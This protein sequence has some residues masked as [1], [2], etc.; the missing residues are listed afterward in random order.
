MGTDCVTCVL[1][2][3]GAVLVSLRKEMDGYPSNHGTFLQKELSGKAISPYSP[4]TIDFSIL[5][6]DLNIVSGMGDL[7]TRLIAT[8]KIKHP[9]RK[10]LV[11]I[12][13]CCLPGGVMPDG[14]DEPSYWYV[15]QLEDSLLHV[16][17]HSSYPKSSPHANED[18]SIFSG[19]LESKS[20][21]E[22][23]RGEGPQIP[24]R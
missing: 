1:D 16:T 21:T 9:D 2:E 8:L 23:C 18:G 13:P 24:G 20:F 14:Y 17:V 11:D 6:P 19:E 12:I 3:H 22:F 5:N 10:N 4:G 7:A 15:V